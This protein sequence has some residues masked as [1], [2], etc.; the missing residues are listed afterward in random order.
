MVGMT[1]AYWKI[2]TIKLDMVAKPVI[3][4]FV[5]LRQEDSMFKASARLS[6]ETLILEKR[7]DQNQSKSFPDTGS[8]KGF[9]ADRPVLSAG[10]TGVFWEDNHT[11]MKPGCWGP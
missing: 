11:S 10:L 3:S 8:V 7:R 1:R 9:V 2:R 4:A 5:R 6:R